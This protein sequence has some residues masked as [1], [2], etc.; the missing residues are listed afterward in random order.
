MIG[1]D[2]MRREMV[3]EQLIARSIRDKRVLEAFG[4]IERE[5]FVPEGER[6]IAY[7]DNPLYIGEGQTISQPYMVALMTQSLDIASGDRVLEVGTGS[8]YQTAILSYLAK[9]VFSIERIEALASRAKTILADLGLLNIHIKI[10]DGT[11]GWAE[12]AP[13][14]KVLVAAG[15]PDIPP[16]LIGQLSPGGKM[17][18]PV[19][20]SFTQ[21]LKLVE[22]S[23]N[24]N[25]TISDICGCVFVPLVGRFGWKDKE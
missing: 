2:E 25:I 19:G 20:R 3:M 5:R 16:L 21:V 11:L 7:T 9:E 12:N 14:D 22:K 17:V 6:G 24:D 23:E 8:G 18:I 13:Y 4:R 1:P 10:G 15:A